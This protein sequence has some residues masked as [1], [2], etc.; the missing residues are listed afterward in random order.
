MMKHRFENGKWMPE[1]GTFVHVPN[2]Q[3]PEVIKMLRDNGQITEEDDTILVSENCVY[4][5]EGE[6]GSCI[7]NLIEGKELPF[8]DFKALVT[9]KLPESWCIQCTEE[10]MKHGAWEEMIESIDRNKSIECQFN[11]FYG[12]ADKYFGGESPGAFGEVLQIETWAALN[13]VEE[14]L[15]TDDQIDEYL[16]SEGYDLGEIE[17]KAEQARQEFICSWIGKSTDEQLINELK[18][19]GYTVSKIY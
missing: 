8:P 18:S 11:W 9:G 14:S 13:P 12:K 3:I 2:E 16:K 5:E 7:S 19:R 17:S 6:W 4:F 15:P 10:S 1:N